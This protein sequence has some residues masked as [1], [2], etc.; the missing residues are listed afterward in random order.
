M[1]RRY[2]VTISSLYHWLSN[3]ETVS[4]LKSWWLPTISLSA[5][6]LVSVPTLRIPCFSEHSRRDYPPYEPMVQAREIC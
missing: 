5:E 6:G 4:S 2:L 3:S 1:R